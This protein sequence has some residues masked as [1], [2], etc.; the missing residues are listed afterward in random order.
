MH[1]QSRYRIT[2]S[3]VAIGALAALWMGRGL[4][5]ADDLLGP[6]TV[7]GGNATWLREPFDE[8]VHAVLVLLLL[9]IPF[10]RRPRGPILIWLALFL[11][12]CAWDRMC[13]QPYLF[14]YA[15]MIVALSAGLRTGLNG[16]RLVLVSVY[17]WSGLSKANASFLHEGMQP[18]FE[19]V[20]PADT[21]ALMQRG[22]A[23]I[24]VLEVLFAIGLATRR[25][26]TASVVLLELMHLSILWMIG[27]LGGDYNH[28]VWPWNLVMMALLPTL[29]LGT[30]ETRA[31]ELLGRGGGVVQATVLV[32]ALVCPGLSYLGLW[33]GYLSFKLYTASSPIARVFVTRP[34][35]E[36]L[37]PSQREDLYRQPLQYGGRS[38]PAFVPLPHWT[39]ERLG[40]FAPPDPVV[41][42]AIARRL[43]ARS[44]DPRAVL[45]A[46]DSA[47][48][49]RTRERTTTFSYPGER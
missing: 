23:A 31:S 9:Q 42:R 47:P 14:Q 24:P 29:F 49:W 2:V 26:R 17:L 43:A 6:V 32:L 41:F 21:A 28:I 33:P 4:F 18:L 44:R 46:I 1:D 19:F 22:A 11:G 7:A 30:S 27:P 35:L 3:L 8:L 10:W 12:R 25:F 34:V 48:D 37:S 45:L 15:L 20:L 39:E 40:A 38:Y 36:T 5:L 16:G 13:W